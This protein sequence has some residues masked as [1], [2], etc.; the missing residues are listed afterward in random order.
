MELAKTAG[1]FAL[2]ALAGI[3]GCY[4]PWLVIRQSKPAGLL[5]AE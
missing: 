1:L 3:V 5:P 4:L 2:S